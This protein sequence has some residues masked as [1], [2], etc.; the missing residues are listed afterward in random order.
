M[1]SIDDYWRDGFEQVEGWVDLR[2]LRYLKCLAAL[3]DARKVTGNIAEIGVHHGRL[4]IALAHLARPG[5]S[6]L[7]IDLFENQELNIDG[8]GIGNLYRLRQNLDTYGPANTRVV[9]V[10]ADTLALSASDRVDLIRSHG[11]F[12][13]FSVDGGHT[14]E[15]LVNDLDFAQ[16]SLSGGGVIMVD[17]Y[18]HRHW[19]GVT[20]GVG[21]FFA[22]TSP[23]I[24]PFLF[25]FNKLF[26]ANASWHDFYFRSISDTFRSEPEF[27]VVRM[28]GSEAVAM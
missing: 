8:S 26:L 24:K 2:L 4:L 21:R 20:E 11:P 27:K 25:A 22:L 9:C 10:K 5:E 18:Y 19:P 3:Q 15:H 1:E 13:M 6:C 14:I 12:R 7:A 17:D 16:S 28:F 23:R